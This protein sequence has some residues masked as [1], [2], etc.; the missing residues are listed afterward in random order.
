MFATALHA[1]TRHGPE[2][3]PTID[4]RPPRFGHFGRACRGQDCELEGSRG[5]ARV[6]LQRR[7]EIPDLLVRQRR[8]MAGSRDLAAGWKSLVDMAAP[9]R[10]IFARTVAARGC[11]IQNL[12]DAPAQAVGGLRSQL[13]E[14]DLLLFLVQTRLLQHLHDR[15]NIDR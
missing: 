7:Y 9:A 15:R 8:V 6:R 1:L 12:L 5:H 10:W 4:L 13:P 14:L 11:P 3:R 2:P